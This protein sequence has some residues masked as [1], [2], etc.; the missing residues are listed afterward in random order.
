MGTNGALFGFDDLLQLLAER[1]KTGRLTV[2]APAVEGIILYDPKTGRLREGAP[3]TEG[4]MFLDN[5]RLMGLIDMEGSTVVPASPDDGVVRWP[6]AGIEFV[7]SL[8]RAT[9]VA[10][11]FEPG[12]TWRGGPPAPEGSIRSVVE[13]RVHV[14]KWSRVETVIPSLNVRPT[15]V[16][17]ASGDVTLDRQDWRILK[18]INGRRNVSALARVTGM[19]ST[20][21]CEQLMGLFRRGLVELNLPTLGSESEVEATTQP[22]EALVPDHVRPTGPRRWYRHLG[23]HGP[24]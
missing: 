17:Q 23:R 19:T 16:S 6:D 9:H 1:R 18:S 14:E 20:G 3:R 8:L 22:A 24:G 13:K 5:G 10:F 2:H 21:A 15:L 11:A 4:V 12:V 7:E